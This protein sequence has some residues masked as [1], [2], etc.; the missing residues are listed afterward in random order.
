MLQKHI[1]SAVVRE[2]NGFHED[3]VLR[4]EHGESRPYRDV[5]SCQS[6]SQSL[7][8]ESLSIED[9]KRRKKEGTCSWESEQRQGS[10]QYGLHE[11]RGLA[12]REQSGLLE[13]VQEDEEG[14]GASKAG[15]GEEE[16][17]GHGNDMEEGGHR[18]DEWIGQNEEGGS[19]QQ[20]ESLAHTAE[21]L[22]QFGASTI[23]RTSSAPGGENADAMLLSAKEAARAWQVSDDSNHEHGRRSALRGPTRKGAGSH[24]FFGR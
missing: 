17:S 2:E 13:S 8:G 1:R 9:M 10:S 16:K 23:A 19:Q 3:F 20:L 15:N 6:D 22:R 21:I 7:V 5:G 4:L 18:S 11:R 14:K 24:R 12:S